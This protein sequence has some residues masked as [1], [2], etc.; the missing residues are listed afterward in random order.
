MKIGFLGD[1]HSNID[2]LKAVLQALDENGVDK[3]FCT[4]DIVG[5][6]AAPA[7]CIDLIRERNIPCVKGNHDEYTTQ[8]GADWLIQPDART[9]IHWTQEVLGDSYIN[10]LAQ[11]PRVIEFKNI[12]I[13]HASH[14]WW[15]RWPYV[16]NEKAAINN[17]IFQ[18]SRISFN[19][20]S[21]V[22]LCVSWRVNERPE[23]EW[24]KNMF[25]PR[26]QK[27]LIAVG[28]VG[29]PRD[30]DPRA[31]CVIY[32]TTQHSLR[33]VRIAYDIAAAQKKILEAG[34]PDTLARRL[35]SG[36]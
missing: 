11:L 16:I 28:S 9:V 25:V 13:L 22:P 32:D 26:K 17:F 18:S 31:C 36:D 12:S 24:L 4:G 19:G 5:Y 2:A 14:V 15:P 33:I 8:L 21:H 10:W 6:G 3:I 7:E 29:Q 20:H 1:I 23:L 34:L 30:G 35:D 27:L